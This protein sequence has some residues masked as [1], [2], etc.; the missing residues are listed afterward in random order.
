MPTYALE[1]MIVGL[2]FSSHRHVSATHVAILRVTRTRIQR[3]LCAGISP[4]TKLY[5]AF[6]KSL[7]T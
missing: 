5:S 6:G 3:Q 2:L 1:H 7:C 4:H